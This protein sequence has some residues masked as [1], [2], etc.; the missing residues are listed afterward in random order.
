MMGSD[1]AGSEAEPPS[2]PQHRSRFFWTTVALAIAAMLLLC[3][4][5]I[6]I[7]ATRG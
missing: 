6:L 3:A 1:E 5:L 2:M 7:A 4:A